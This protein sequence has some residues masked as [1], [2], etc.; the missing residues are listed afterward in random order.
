MNKIEIAKHIRRRLLQ[1]IYEAKSGHPGGSLS[2]VEILVQL[3]WD[4]MIDDCDK[5]ILSKG[6]ACPAWY[7]VLECMCEEHKYSWE[8]AKL[9]EFGSKYQG[10]PS[11][12]H[13]P[14]VKTSTGSLGQGFGFAA[15]VALGKKALRR[16]E[17]VY[18]LLGDGELQEGMVWETAM[19]AAHYKLKKLCAIVDYNKMQS[20]DYVANVMGLEPL[21]D[22]WKA[23][24]WDVYEVDGHSYDELGAALGRLGKRNMPLAVIAHTVK[25]K[26]VKYMEGDPAWHG[27]VELS[28]E[29]F[30]EAVNGLV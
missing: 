16:R 14:E 20:D 23:F 10:H 3:Y 30:E 2:C 26:G 13:L 25:G 28:G 5:F 22:K 9:R 19:F 15:G 7:A 24:G 29:Q 17:R 8:A 21:M 27:S 6:H 1:L 18:V 12:W 4:T 11:V